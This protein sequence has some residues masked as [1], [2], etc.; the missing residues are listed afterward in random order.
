[1][2]LSTAAGLILYIR[3]GHSSA[4]NPPVDPHLFMGKNLSP[5]SAWQDPTGSDASPLFPTPTPTPACFDIDVNYPVCIVCEIHLN[6]PLAICLFFSYVGYN[7][8][9][10]RI[11]TSGP[12]DGHSFTNFQRSSL[13]SIVQPHISFMW[14]DLFFFFFF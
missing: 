8:K 10:Q 4:Q 3:S 13:K 6:S 12:P 2:L 7:S 14:N 5:D 1:M 9:I 11:R